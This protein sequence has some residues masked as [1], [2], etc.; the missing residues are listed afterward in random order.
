MIVPIINKRE[1]EVFVI[2]A[3]ENNLVFCK[4]IKNEF[5][6]FERFRAPVKQISA[7]YQFV[8]RMVIKI[9]LLIKSGDQF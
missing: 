4:E 5:L 9:P 2:A 1:H 8:W 7:Y 6:H 3:D